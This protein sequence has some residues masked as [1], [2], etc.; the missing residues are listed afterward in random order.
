[1]GLHLVDHALG[2]LGGQISFGR[3]DLG[4]ALF[5]VSIPKERKESA[6]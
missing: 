2:S 6:P 5:V 1:M 3:G 4:G